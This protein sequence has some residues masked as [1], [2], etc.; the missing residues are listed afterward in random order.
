MTEKYN[1]LKSKIK[2]H[3]KDVGSVEVQVIDLTD[4]IAVL[5]EHVKTHQKDFSSK[6]G[7]LRLV[8]RRRRCL[9]YLKSK[10]FNVYKDLL[11]G[12]GLRK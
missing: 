1:E 4:K 5:S 9:E 12:L 7:L 3:A 11:S 10:K 2:L 8:N 6:F